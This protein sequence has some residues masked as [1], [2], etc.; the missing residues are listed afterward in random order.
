MTNP[1]KNYASPP[2]DFY[3]ARLK[4]KEMV[5]T[6]EEQSKIRRRRCFSLARSTLFK[7]NMKQR[8]DI[9]TLV[10]LYMKWETR[11]LS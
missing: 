1:Y 2:Q 3:R 8:C 9:L 11:P 7:E 6:R 4:R 10:S 5:R